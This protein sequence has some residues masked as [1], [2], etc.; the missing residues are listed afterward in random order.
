MILTAENLVYILP[1]VSIEIK[2]W[3]HHLVALMSCQI[4]SQSAELLCL[5]RIAIVLLNKA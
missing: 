1:S 2:P 3:Q 4:D 5:L